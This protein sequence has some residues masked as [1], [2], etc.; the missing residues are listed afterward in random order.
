MELTFFDFLLFTHF[1]P[2]ITRTFGYQLSDLDGRGHLLPV[3]LSLV[4]MIPY[5][6]PSIHYSKCFV[7]DFPHSVKLAPYG[8]MM[9]A[10]LVS[11]MMDF[12]ET[13]KA[14][15]ANPG[16]SLLICNGSRSKIVKGAPNWGENLWDSDWDPHFHSLLPLTQQTSNILENSLNHWAFPPQLSWK[17]KNWPTHLIVMH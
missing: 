4:S 8:G 11:K 15:F 3:Y 13:N 9:F 2:S 17:P 16:C 6:F 10:V 1:L 14:G 7:L 5:T 12:F